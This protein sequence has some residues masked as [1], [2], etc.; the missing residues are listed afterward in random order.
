MT[1]LGLPEAG[2]ASS[3]SELSSNAGSSLLRPAWSRPVGSGSWLLNVVYR[4]PPIRASSS[5]IASHDVNEKRSRRMPCRK[6]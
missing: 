4:A 3:A 6:S 5:S 1:A 2:E